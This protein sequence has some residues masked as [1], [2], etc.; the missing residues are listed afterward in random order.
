MDRKKL[1]SYLSGKKTRDYTY[2]IAFFLIFS[3]FVFVLI[4]PNL[5]E[6]FSSFEKIDQLQKVDNFYEK[7]IEKSLTLQKDMEQIADKTY[8][9]DDAIASRPKVNKMLDD[10][11]VVLDK[12]DLK[13]DKIN[14]FDVNLKDAGVKHTKGVRITMTVRGSFT[15]ISD[16]VTS[17]YKQRRLKVIKSLIITKDEEKISSR[18]VHKY[19][20]AGLFAAGDCHGDC[21]V[22]E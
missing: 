9:L 17:I 14:L 4:R 10:I 19:E 11:K 12:N 20:R 3:F 5:I 22:R 6:I 1:L 21:L 8:L 18:Y 15:G 7:Q 2:M 16:F 13:V